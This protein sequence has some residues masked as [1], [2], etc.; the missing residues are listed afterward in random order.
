MRNNINI[1][2]YIEVEIY[3]LKQ[4]TDSLII[5]VQH[6]FLLFCLE[7]ITVTLISALSFRLAL[8]NMSNLG[9]I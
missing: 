3:Y 1:H 7:P 2:C 6:L 4:G 8:S 9:V 5:T